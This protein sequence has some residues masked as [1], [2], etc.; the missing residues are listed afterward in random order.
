MSKTFKCRELGGTCEQPFSGESL[1]EILQQGAPHMMTDEAHQA[2]IMDM[3]A[4]TGEN[5]DQW[6]DRMQREFDDRAE[7]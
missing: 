1:A 5:K 6:I 4:R 2:S 3:E 7:D